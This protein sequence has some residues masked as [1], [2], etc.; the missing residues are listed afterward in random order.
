MESYLIITSLLLLCLSCQQN[1]GEAK[2]SPEAIDTSKPKDSVMLSADSTLGL[3]E[4]LKS[5]QPIWEVEQKSTSNRPGSISRLYE[6]GQIYA[7]SNSRRVQVNGKLSRETAPYAWRLDA[8]I[9][10]EGI[11]RV[12]ELLKSEF[13]KLPANNS[14]TTGADQ[15]VVIR[16]SYI[17]GEAHSVTLP[18]SATNNLP[19]VI[20]DIDYAIQS[21]IIPGAVPLAQ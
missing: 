4:N 18:T 20:R 6:N 3:P 13:T 9:Q 17:D 5:A 8:Q 2:S 1:P 7:W 11:K 10:P 16:R 19:Q 21:N 12:Q 15:G 14:V